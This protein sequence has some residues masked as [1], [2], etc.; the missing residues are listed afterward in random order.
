MAAAKLN[1]FFTRSMPNA[2]SYKIVNFLF[3]SLFFFAFALLLSRAP[4]SELT[5]AFGSVKKWKIVWSLLFF[6]KWCKESNL[7]F[8]CGWDSMEIRIRAHT[9]LTLKLLSLRIE[10]GMEIFVVKNSTCVCEPW[11]LVFPRTPTA[12]NIDSNEV[13]EI[14]SF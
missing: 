1:S 8:L 12:T 11:L 2:F 3:I 6:V 9:Y 7:G 13:T 4:L 10:L 5:F 14:E